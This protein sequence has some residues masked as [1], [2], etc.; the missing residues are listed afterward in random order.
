[1]DIRY[2]LLGDR[3]DRQENPELSLLDLWDDKLGLVQSGVS[4][5][6]SELDVKSEQSVQEDE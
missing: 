4:Y 1:L 3:D 5:R 6:E 2:L